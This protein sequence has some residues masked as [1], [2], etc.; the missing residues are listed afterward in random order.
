MRRRWGTVALGVAALL[1]WG[2]ARGEIPAVPASAGPERLLVWVEVDRMRL[3][4]YENGAAAAVYPIASGTADTPSPVGVFR[5]TSRF[6]T[7][8]SAIPSAIS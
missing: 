4:V 6:A 7:R 2:W 1:M 3:T 5:V 8:S